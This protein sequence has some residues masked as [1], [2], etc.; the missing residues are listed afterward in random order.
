MDTLI[1]LHREDKTPQ[2]SKLLSS[3]SSTK[4]YM[5]DV[6]Y[7]LIGSINVGITWTYQGESKLIFYSQINLKPL[8]QTVLKILNK[9]NSLMDWGTYASNAIV[10][11]NKNGL[12]NVMD[13]YDKVKEFL[14]S[15]WMHSSHQLHWS[16]L[17]WKM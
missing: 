7:P 4:R 8:F 16:T 11:G 17:E 10:S 6:V 3:Y 1:A 14:Q 13:N 9:P 5:S 15:T 2:K 12:L